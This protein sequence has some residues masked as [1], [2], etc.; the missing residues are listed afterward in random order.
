M[1][2]QIV[3]LA[4]LKMRSAEDSNN[5]LREFLLLSSKTMSLQTLFFHCI[6]YALE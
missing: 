4:P 1:C 5:E 2:R 3:S 6:M